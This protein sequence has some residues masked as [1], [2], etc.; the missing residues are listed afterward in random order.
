MTNQ[1]IF[2]ILGAMLCVY[3]GYLCLK[4]IKENKKI[5]TEI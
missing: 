2:L 4:S 3:A 5:K 1:E